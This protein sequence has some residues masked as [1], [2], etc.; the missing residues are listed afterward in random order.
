MPAANNFP[1]FIVVAGATA[2]G[3]S[4]AAMRLAEQLPIEIVSG[5]SMQF[6]RMLDIGVAKPSAADRKKVPHHLIDIFDLSERVD[7]RRFVELATT[8]IKEISSRGKLPCVVGGTGFYLKSLI[9]GLDDL[10][11]SPDLRAEL[12]A[13]YAAP[14]QF[15]ALKAEMRRRDPAAFARW[16]THQRK[17][18]RALE[19]LILT[20]G[21][22][23]TELQTG[24][25]KPRFNV[26]T[27]IIDRPREE[28]RRRIGQRTAAMLAAGWIEET[29]RAVAAGLLESPT[30]RQA[31][32]YPIIADYL[33]GAVSAEVMRELIS[34]RTWQFARRQLT[35]FR[36]QHPEAEWIVCGEDGKDPGDRL[37][38]A[39]AGV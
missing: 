19:V 30:A 29:A 14:E 10:P 1:D 24:E 36:H 7:V 4:A 39:L 23:I 6:Y 33:S 31:L 28:L 38:F 3:K 26:R 11:S 20:G 37:Y 34:T 16:Q 12:D 13:R 8:A 15:D 25:K 35:W 27:F 22:S 32:G 5:D 17:L 9:C 21:R 18:L 2:S